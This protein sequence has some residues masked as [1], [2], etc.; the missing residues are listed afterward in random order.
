MQKLPLHL[1][2][3]G[4]FLLLFGCA[5]PMQSE[6]SP[7][8]TITPAAAATASPTPTAASTATPA[9][10]A[11]SAPQPFSLLWIPD[12]QNMTENDY[13][14]L[15]AVA[16]WA[17]QNREAY[18][19]R[20]AVHTGD[21][22]NGG[23]G[24]HAW[25]R[26]APT[27]QRLAGIVPLMTAAGNHDIGRGDRGDYTFY[28]RWRFD[29]SL[30][31][32]QL[33]EGGRGSYA[34]LDTDIGAFLL[35]SIGAYPDEASFAWL[36]ETFAKHPDRI[37][38]LVIHD[39]LSPNGEHTS[40]GKRVYDNVVVPSPN[41][42]LVLC[43]HNAPLGHRIDT[44]DDDG[45]GTAERTVHQLLYNLQH[46][47]K[48]TG[49]VRILTFSPDGSLTVDSYSPY[50]DDHDYYTEKTAPKKAKESLRIEAAF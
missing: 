49:Y 38:I 17:E 44:L 39:Y 31:E 24:N 46:D 10:T 15:E 16:D 50:L 33:F 25:E 30:P 29:T 22:V 40:Y 14:P 28:L 7:S 45:D 21:I 27:M 36:R 48:K 6:P 11:T 19:L 23:L 43:G 1:C 42:R 5:A 32:E 20:Y 26:I 2:L 41:L 37:G 3:L 12:S 8:V 34:L 9:P 4:C 47:K 35:V 18:N 13:A